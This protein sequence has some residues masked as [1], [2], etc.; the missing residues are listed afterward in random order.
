[1]SRVQTVPALFQQPP[2]QRQPVGQAGK[3]VF[4]RQRLGEAGG[5]E[6][7]LRTTP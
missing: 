5:H 6:Q 2:L 7:V 1:M 4:L 3:A